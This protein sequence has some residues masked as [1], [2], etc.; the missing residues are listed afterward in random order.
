MVGKHDCQGFLPFSCIQAFGYYHD[1]ILR[2]VITNI[3]FKGAYVLT[4]AVEDF[5]KEN[6]SVVENCDIDCIIPMPLS[7][8]R[9]KDRGFNQSLILAEV[10]KKVCKF[11]QPLKKDLLVRVLHGE[12]QSSLGNDYELRSCN[13]SDSFYCKD[14]VPE[15]ILLVDDVITTG[16]TASEAAKVLKQN[17][18]KH[19]YLVCLAIGA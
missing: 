5:A 8:K 15:K 19:V 16:A 12:P 6:R 3:K 4:G 13:I 2:K 11:S 1:P 10:I 17:G 7:E 14:L 9:M 18:A